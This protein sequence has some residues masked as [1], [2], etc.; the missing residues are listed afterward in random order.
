MELKTI[1]RIFLL[2]LLVSLAAC[3]TGTNGLPTVYKAG[4]YTERADGYGGAIKVSALFSDDSITA[5]A[6]DSHKESLN[7]APVA[8]A[9]EQIPQAIVEGQTLTVDVVSGATHTSK[10]IIKAV[11]KCVLKA[12]GDGAVE[13]L[14]R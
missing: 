10:G 12:G 3:E 7:R 11:E 5:I 8:A 13:K 1:T 6:V 14:K 2:S 4:A 9:L